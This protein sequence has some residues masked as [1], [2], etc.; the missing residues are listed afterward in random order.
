[1]EYLPWVVMA[2]GLFLLFVRRQFR[3]REDGADETKYTH[4]AYAEHPG[5]R[6]LQVNTKDV[7]EP[8]VLHAPQQP[9][10]SAI[11][12]PIALSLMVVGAALTVILLPSYYGEA[13]QKWAFGIIGLILGYWFKK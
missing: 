2:F 13:H 1:M 6:T 11:W 7:K 10:G 5:G 9:H 3:E 8:T 12:M 4:I